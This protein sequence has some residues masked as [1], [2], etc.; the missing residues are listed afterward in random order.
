M[1]PGVVLWMKAKEAKAVEGNLCL[2][3]KQ[4][5]RT[6]NAT[7]VQVIKDAIAKHLH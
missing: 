3:A 6:P 2:F 5:E 7:I 1:L 4:K